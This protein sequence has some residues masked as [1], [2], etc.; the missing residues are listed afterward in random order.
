MSTFTSEKIRI[1][2]KIRKFFVN[3]HIH[4]TESI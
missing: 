2:Q 4:E 3:N 1:S